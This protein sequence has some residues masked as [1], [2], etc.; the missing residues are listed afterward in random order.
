MNSQHF[1]RNKNRSLTSVATLVLGLSLAV[2]AHAQRSGNINQLFAFTC[3]SGFH[4]DTCPQG[5][6]PDI[7]LQ[8]SDGNFYGAAQV[9][10]EGVSDPQ[11][12]TLFKLTPSGEFTKLFTFTQGSSGFL[13][14]NNPASGFV[15]A[16]DGF[17]YGTNFNGGKQN[18]GVL[19]RISKTG[20]DFKVLHNFCS[21]TNCADGSIPNGLLLGQD[22]N[23][24]G[25]TLEGGSSVGLCPSSGCGTIFRF[26]PTTGAFAVLH[27]LT[28]VADGHQP[29]GSLEPFGM[30]Q[31]ANGNF[32]GVSQGLDIESFNEDIFQFTLAGQ[33]TVQFKSA[34][35]HTGISGL[36]QGANGNL[37]GAFES[38]AGR[39]AGDINFF[40][41][42]T[43]GTGFVAFA[44][45][46]ALV[47]TTTIP[48]LF[49][50]SDGNLW[51]TNFTDSVATMGSVFSINPQNGAVLQ[52]FAFDGA[53]GDSPLASV[54]QAADGSFVGTTELGGTISGG[55]NTFA[56]GT[57]WTLDAGLP[58]PAPAITLLNSTSGSVGSTVL[59]NGNNFIGTTAV[60]FNG[61]SASFQVLNTQFV[62]ATLPAGAT[63]GPVTVTN[64]GG[65]A[66]STQ[67]FTVN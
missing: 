50:A 49:L 27:R 65:R 29:I 28:A 62:S 56:D 6:R 46:T 35:N 67:T 8:A 11:G 24:Y 57:V 58:A 14:G 60:S 22:G 48:S 32:Y 42:S 36:T 17:L 47:G 52:T 34:L 39:A 59:I 13:D 66:T 5:A 37:Y 4:S 10:D 44:P 63:T 55:N 21:S 26:E 41:V 12:G 43:G 3:T 1:V 18:D 2:T 64:A 16:N 33:F 15:E 20:A 45:F 40:E 38:I 23:L 31:A 30:I 19:F 54:I 53:N 61:V 51:D 7:I 25:T 9:T